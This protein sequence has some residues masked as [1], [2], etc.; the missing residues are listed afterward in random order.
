M[1]HL[2][3]ELERT[4]QELAN[5]HAGFEETIEQQSTARTEPLQSKTGEVQQASTAKLQNA[6]TELARLRMR[7][8]AAQISAAKDR[9]DFET[10]LAANDAAHAE[11][12]TA[13]VSDE[14]KA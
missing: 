5:A 3:A 10:R 9:K 14:I 8:A 1:Q 4:Q 7:A 13:Q 12:L 6:S 11:R 2:Q